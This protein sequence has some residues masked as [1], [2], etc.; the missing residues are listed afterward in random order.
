M[1]ERGVALGER[2]LV[3]V[4]A[5]CRGGGTLA[6]LLDAAAAAPRGVP[7]AE[8]LQAALRRAAFEGNLESVE[9]LI[10]RGAVPGPDVHGGLVPARRCV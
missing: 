8:L 3:R 6:A 4:A 10:D 9:L 2:V 1:G 7:P 5:Y